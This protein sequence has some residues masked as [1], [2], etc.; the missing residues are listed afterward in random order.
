MELV[1]YVA[2]SFVAGF[3][4]GLVALDAWDKWHAKISLQEREQL[5]EMRRKASAV[6]AAQT[7]KERAIKAAQ[8]I[9]SASK[10]NGA[11]SWEK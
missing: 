6:K 1:L 3:A 8:A 7:R 2:G 11:A 10:G 4:A 9:T 5:A